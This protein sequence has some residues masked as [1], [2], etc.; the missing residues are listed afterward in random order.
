MSR[1]KSRG[2]AVTWRC[3]GGPVVPLRGRTVAPADPVE[4]NLRVGGVHLALD[5]V[6]DGHVHQRPVTMATG[7]LQELREGRQYLLHLSDE[8]IEPAGNGVS[9]V[10]SR[11]RTI[12]A[13]RSHKEVS[14]GRKSSEVRCGR[15]Q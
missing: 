2:C 5:V 3:D 14:R 9:E 4:Q 7:A 8:G 1:D 11:L 12:P 6:V 15:S 13:Q 10:K